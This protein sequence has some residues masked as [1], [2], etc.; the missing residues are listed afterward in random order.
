MVERG[1]VDP[2]T[3]KTISWGSSTPSLYSILQVR[4][5]IKA[6]ADWWSHTNK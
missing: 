6:V 2:D 1:G 4:M 5:H 3:G